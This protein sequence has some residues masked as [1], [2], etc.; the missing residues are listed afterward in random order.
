[1]TVKSHISKRTTRTPV[2]APT[3]KSRLPDKKNIG[4]IA[5]C[6]SNEDAAE[7][8]AIIQQGCEGIDRDVW[9]NLP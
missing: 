4:K 5:G 8:K 9:K 1:M 7:L 2:L 3:I 6:L